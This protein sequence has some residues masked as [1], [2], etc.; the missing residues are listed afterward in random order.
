MLL[1]PIPSDERTFAL[2]CT[3]LSD[4]GAYRT[5]SLVAGQRQWLPARYFFLVVV[6][7]RSGCL[8]RACS[9]HLSAPEQS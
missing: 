9:T 7:D 4:H 1:L 6:L 3:L 2:V 5:I 8:P